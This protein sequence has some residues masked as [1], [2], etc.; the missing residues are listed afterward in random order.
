MVQLSSL[1]LSLALLR[2]ERYCNDGLAGLNVAFR[3]SFCICSFV[4]CR[5]SLTLCLYFCVCVS[6][7]CVAAFAS[8]GSAV[9]ESHRKYQRHFYNNWRATVFMIVS[10]AHLVHINTSLLKW[11]WK[12][13]GFLLVCACELIHFLLIESVKKKVNTCRTNPANL[14]YVVSY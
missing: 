13:S 11:K 2:E 5:Q 6:P 1:G 8:P 7:T 9:E 3:H 14:C 12:V 10:V 4:V